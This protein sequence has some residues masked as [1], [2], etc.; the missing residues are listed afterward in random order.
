MGERRVTVK[1]FVE[2]REG[3]PLMPTTP[4]KARLLLKVGQAEIVGRK[5]FKIRYCTDHQAMFSQWMWALMRVTGI[6]AI[7]R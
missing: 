2:N 3:K 4:R 6:L 1:V 7:Q 5:P